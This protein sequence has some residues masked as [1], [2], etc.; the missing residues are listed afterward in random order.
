MRNIKL[1]IEY[2]GT[3]YCGW[4]SQKNGVSVQDVIE[5]ALRKLTGQ[6]SRLIGSGRTDSGVHAKEQ[7]ANF[8]TN[9]KRSFKNLKNALNSKLPDDIVIISTKEVSRNFHAQHSA[10]SKIY[11]YTFAHQSHLS[12]FYR[13]YATKYSH[14]LDLDLMRRE[15][16]AL[17]GKHDFSAFEGSK[18]KRNSA[19]RVIKNIKIKANGEFIYID[20]ESN[21]FLY[22]MVRNIVGTL[23][24]IGRGYF[25][26]GS[27]KKILSSKDRKM[28]GRTA[29]A[30]GLCLMRVKY[31]KTY[32]SQDR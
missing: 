14:E 29:P 24:D 28:A 13:N 6:K 16:K 17:I 21:G 23:I 27:M 9:S 5:E 10:R 25:K 11:R 19:V 32:T 30:K 1:T 3:N 15:V 8:K 26:P 7:V 4:Q 12:P 22:N 20:I 18:S 31:G 2:D